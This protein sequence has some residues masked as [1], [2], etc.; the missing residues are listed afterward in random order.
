[1]TWFSQKVQRPCFRTIFDHFWSFLPDRGFFEKNVLNLTITNEQT[2]FTRELTKEH[3]TKKP[4]TKDLKQKKSNLL[5]QM[6][7]NNLSLIL[8]NK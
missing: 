6:H 5:D 2:L 4:F 8:K 7:I 1:M 3:T